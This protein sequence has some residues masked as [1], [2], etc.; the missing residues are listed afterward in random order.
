[1]KPICI[2]CQQFFRPEKNGF[3][4]IEGMP[5]SGARPG[6]VDAHL[7]KPYK[8]WSGDKWK[9]PGCGAEIVVGTG[10]Y[11]IREHFMP[12]FQDFVEKMGAKYQV[13]DC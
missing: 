10:Q 6:K 11:A 3:A 9:C 4:F 2:P 12:D 13:N 7:W 1:M 8:L 5:E